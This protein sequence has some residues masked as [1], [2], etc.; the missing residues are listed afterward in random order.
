[1]LLGSSERSLVDDGHRGDVERGPCL[2][3]HGSFDSVCEAGNVNSVK[4]SCDIK[5]SAAFP[6]L[7]VDVLY[8]TMS[9]SCRMFFFSA[10][11]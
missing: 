7:H 9:K 5:A 3:R 2:N 1:M 4:I 6:I 10:D 8:I 11:N